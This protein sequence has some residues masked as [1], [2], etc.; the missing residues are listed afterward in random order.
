MSTVAL[1]TRFDRRRNV[2]KIIVVFWSHYVFST[3]YVHDSEKQ[4]WDRLGYF[5]LVTRFWYFIFR[6]DPPRL[7]EVYSKSGCKSHGTVRSISFFSQPP[8]RVCEVTSKYCDV[9]TVLLIPITFNITSSTATNHSNW[10]LMMLLLTL[11]LLLS[12]ICQSSDPW[13]LKRPFTYYLF[14]Y[15]VAIIVFPIHSFWYCKRSLSSSFNYLSSSIL[16][17]LLD[18]YD[19]A[20]LKASNNSQIVDLSCFEI[21][22]VYH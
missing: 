3:I 4:L 19:F 14:T 22:S 5:W 11:G 6:V 15:L 8:S 9:P 21:H 17:A 13:F 18:P 20:R 16:L 2:N 10:P 7:C 1:D 12:T